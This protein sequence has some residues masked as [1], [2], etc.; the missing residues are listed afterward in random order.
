MEN[1]SKN[2]KIALGAGVI[3]LL[4]FILPFMSVFFFSFSLMDLVTGG[5]ILG[6]A[7]DFGEAFGGDGEG[8]PN[9]YQ[10]LLF[11][12]AAIAAVWFIYKDKYSLAKIAFVIPIPLLILT[13][14]LMG[15]ESDEQIPISDVF[16]Y[17]AIGF[18]TSILS[19][20]VGFIY[21]KE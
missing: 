18:Y 11:P 13:F 9:Q 19:P 16:R 3:L 14:I 8:I 12:I 20:I 2:K 5:G 1:F 10:L 17:G 4:S 7:A 21:S 15:G 6:A